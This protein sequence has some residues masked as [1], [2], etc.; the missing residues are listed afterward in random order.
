MLSEPAQFS[1]PL[2][3]EAIVAGF[4]SFDPGLCEESERIQEARAA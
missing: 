3:A 2:V 4:R 1:I